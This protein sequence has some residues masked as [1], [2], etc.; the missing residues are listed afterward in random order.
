LLVGINSQPFLA[1]I[2]GLERKINLWRNVNSIKETL[3]NAIFLILA[4]P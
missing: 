2:D 1:R 4:Q 3:T